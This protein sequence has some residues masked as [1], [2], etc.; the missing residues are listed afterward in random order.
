MKINIEDPSGNITSQDIQVDIEAPDL[1]LLDV[2]LRDQEISGKISEGKPNI[3]VGFLR[4]RNGIKS[5]LEKTIISEDGGGFVLNNLGDKGDIILKDPETNEKLV[6]ILPTGR[7]IV[8]D[9]KKVKTTISTNPFAI[10]INNSKNESL[11]T[12]NFKTNPAKNDDI[13][14]ESSFKE[15]SAKKARNMKE[16]NVI[17]YNKDDYFVWKRF[18][19]G[20]ALIDN[21]NNKT[22]GVLDNYGKFKSTD[23]LKTLRIKPKKVK[24]EGNP[25]IFQIY[26]DE[27]KK[28]ISEFFIPVK[29]LIVQ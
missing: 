12:I 6:E 24:E 15:I 22:L 27:T 1:R 20:M 13:K 10:K 16:I 4:E 8:I 7:P 2:S 5:I 25:V 29:E 23:F 9:S 26:N 28:L 11:V 21:L 3:K 19:G 14:I 18:N 17:D